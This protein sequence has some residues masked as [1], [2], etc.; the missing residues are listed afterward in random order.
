[1]VGNFEVD[2]E[3]QQRVGH[4]FGPL[5]PEMR[6]DTA[7]MDRIHAY[8]PGWDIPKIDK[9]I[10]TSHFGLVSDFLSECWSELRKLKGAHLFQNNRVN[11]GGALSGRDT[12]AVKKTISGLLKIIHPSLK[13]IPDE[14]LEWATRI[15]LESRRRVK[16]QQKR[17]GAAEFRNTQFSYYMGEDGVEQH[18]STPELKSQNLIGEDPL[19]PGQAYAFSPGFEDENPG[20]YRVEINEGPGTNKKILNKP[21]PKPFQECVDYAYQNL[22]ARAKQ[23]IGDKDPRAREFSIQL[24]GYDTSKSGAKIGMAVLLALCT[25]MLKKCLRGGLVVVG[26]IN[27]GGSIDQV[28]NPVIIAEMAFEKGATSLLMPVSCR[29]QLVDLS[30]DLATKIDIKFYSDASDALLKAM[31]V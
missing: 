25:S 4:L 21:V 13:D 8:L 5:P 16:E 12:T 2:V 1:M 30:D 7:F 26:N 28:H 18:V 15:A 27:L 24:R 6:D 9:S 3:H 23:L 11:F 31:E 29:K 22:C 17:I 14:D 10:L 20:L 19:E